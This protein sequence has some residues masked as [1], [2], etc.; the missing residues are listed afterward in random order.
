MSDST[1]LSDRPAPASAESASAPEGLEINWS[2]AA[3]TPEFS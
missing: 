2:A 3:R 1:V